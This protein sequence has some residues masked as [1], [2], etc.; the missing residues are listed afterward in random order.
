MLSAAENCSCRVLLRRAPRGATPSSIPALR[1]RPCFDDQKADRGRPASQLRNFHRTSSLRYATQRPPPSLL[2]RDAVAY[3][4]FLLAPRPDA[5]VPHGAA[6]RPDLTPTSGTATTNNPAGSSP[7]SS[8]QRALIALRGGDVRRLL[9]QLRVIQRLSREELRN[10][11]ATL[12]RTTFT[13]FFRALDPL[14]VARDCDPAADSYISTGMVKLLHLESGIDLWGVRRLFT[15]LLQQLLLL[16]QAMKMAGY[17]LHTEE[18]I[19]LMRC[20]GACCDISGVKALWNDMIRGPAVVWRNEETYIEFI[21]ARFLTEPLYTNYEKVT[22]MVTPRNLHRSRLQLHDNSVR[23]LDNLHF[24]MRKKRGLFG[25][26]KDVGHMEGLARALR[27]N[28]HILKLLRTVVLARS[29]RM[30]ERLL[31]ALMIGLGRSGSLRLIGTEILEKYFGIK[32]PHPIA[33]ES[34]DKDKQGAATPE[35]PRIVPTVRLMR[36]IVEV[37]GSNAEIG[38]AVQLVE[39]LSTTYN[40]PIPPDVWQDLLEWTYIMS[41]PPASTAWKIAGMRMKIPNIQAVEM[42]WNA[43]TAPPHNHIPTFQNYSL[44]IRSLI[45]QTPVGLAPILSHMR[46]AVALYDEQCREYEAAAF[47]YIH[48]LRDGVISSAATHRF[49]SARFKKQSMWYDI[50]RWCRMILKN[51]PYSTDSPFPN[52]AVPGFIEEFRPFLKNAIQY[53]IPTGDVKLVDPALETFR[54]IPTGEIEQRVPIRNARKA[55]IQKV[56]VIPKFAVLSSHSLGRLKPTHNPLT[57]IAPD[58]K[59]FGGPVRWQSRPAK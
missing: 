55:W 57:L 18:Y 40:L 37:Y 22:R 21:E 28:S 34:K 41:T 44:L 19:A 59:A 9:V 6:V 30:S 56:I 13:E 45:V 15:G 5:D 42:I 14:R 27:G 24:G 54:V 33:K 58:R 23:R 32:T 47:A 17:S 46:E 51:Q 43:M 8:F 36:A 4:Q 10:A 53:R 3:A 7:A 31:C 26:N 29:F 20:A 1:L 2:S 49:E 48:H 35:R 50:S 12:P 16:M 25:L 39:Y 11:A 52:P 38:V